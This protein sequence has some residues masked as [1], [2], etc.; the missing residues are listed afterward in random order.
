MSR[1]VLR[2]RKAQNN[3]QVRRSEECL[4][5]ESHKEVI[6]VRIGILRIQ[7]DACSP[8]RGAGVLKAIVVS[9]LVELSRRS[10]KVGQERIRKLKAVAPLQ[11]QRSEH[12]QNTT[13][14]RVKMLCTFGTL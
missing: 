9:S 4:R 5:W 8:V 6:Y 14:H 3:R 2:R 11:M 13:S 7:E 10:D 12:L 1:G